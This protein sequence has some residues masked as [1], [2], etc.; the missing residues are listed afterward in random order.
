VDDDVLRLL[1]LLDRLDGAADGA[2]V[3]TSVRMPTALRDAAA[4]AVR[5]GLLSSVTEVTVRGLQAELEAVAN[6]AVLDAHYGEHPEA[7]PDRWDVAMAA[8][9]LSAHPLATRPDLVRRAADELGR[10]VADP[11]PDEVLAYAAGL[12]AAA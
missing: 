6:R 9:E 8:A 3:G 11:S 12:A 2:T 10:I 1:E 7:R 5:A 4:A